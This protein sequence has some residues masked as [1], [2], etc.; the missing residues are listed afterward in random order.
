[1]RG[2][3]YLKQVLLFFRQTLYHMSYD[4]VVN[5]EVCSDVFSHVVTTA[6]VQCRS[7]RVRTSITPRL[8]GILT[9]DDRPRMK[10]DKNR[11]GV[12]FSKM[13]K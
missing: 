2:H 13:K 11:S 12:W 8:R 7:E 1:M 6:F 10:V 9:L 3:L 5:D 4:P